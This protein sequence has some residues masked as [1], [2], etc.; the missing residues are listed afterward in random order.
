MREH[1]GATKEHID[2]IGVS[3]GA[4]QRP[5]TWCHQFGDDI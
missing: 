2:E 5:V 3:G 1:G 4:K